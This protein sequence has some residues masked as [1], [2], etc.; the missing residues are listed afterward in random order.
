[1]MDSRMRNELDRHITG[2][3]GEDR[4]KG[5]EPEECQLCEALC[6]EDDV[7]PKCGPMKPYSVVI[8]V[9]ARNE[10]HARE[11]AMNGYGDVTVQEA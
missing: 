2:N 10:D 1:M 6:D 8:A 7:C 9:N 4:F 3:Y 5:Q 11:Q